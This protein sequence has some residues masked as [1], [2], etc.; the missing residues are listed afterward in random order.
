MFLA[1]KMGLVP[2]PK[3]VRLC[4][5]NKALRTAIASAEPLHTIAKRFDLCLEYINAM[6]VVDIRLKEK[7]DAFIKA[8]RQSD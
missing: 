2:K 7:R 4:I 5:G 3:W 8:T 1:S 6:L